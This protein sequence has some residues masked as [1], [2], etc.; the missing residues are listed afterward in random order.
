MKPLIVFLLLIL[1]SANIP[2]PPNFRCETDDQK[3]LKKI[4]AKYKVKHK[5][6]IKHC[7]I[8]YAYTYDHPVWLVGNLVRLESGFNRLAVSYKGATGL[9]QI[10]P[11]LHNKEMYK[12]KD[13]NF[14]KFLL[15]LSNVNH[16]KYLYHIGLN[17]F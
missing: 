14:G 16:N 15:G 10:M 8:R 7:I 12:C 3:Y 17:S 1:L 11:G 6:R 13:G 2:K 9:L 5:K 4:M